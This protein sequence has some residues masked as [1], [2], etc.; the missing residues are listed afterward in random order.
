M[1]PGVKPMI[2]LGQIAPGVRWD[3]L[4]FHNSRSSNFS[5]LQYGDGVC[6]YI[7]IIYLQDF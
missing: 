7:F 5:R 1:E 6:K 4:E 2:S 3:L